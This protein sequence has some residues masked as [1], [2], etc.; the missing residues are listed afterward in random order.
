MFE[1][2]KESPIVENVKDIIIPEVTP[3]CSEGEWKNVS[4]RKLRSPLPKASKQNQ[5]KVHTEN[6]FEYFRD[7]IE[8]DKINESVFKTFVNCVIFILQTKHH[9][10]ITKKVPI[11]KTK[12][13]LK[14]KKAK[15]ILSKA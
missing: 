5:F 15:M 4:R 1:E 6:R 11:N 7:N 13:N 14:V 9:W 2:P 10:K 8:E 3:S 12:E